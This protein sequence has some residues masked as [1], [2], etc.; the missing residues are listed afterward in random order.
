MQA[1]VLAVV[2]V[3]AL[4][5][6]GGIPTSSDVQAG[7]IVTET[8]PSAITLPAAPRVGASQQEILTGFM[9][10][11]TSPEKGYE[12]ARMFLTTAASE[13]WSPN[14]SVQVTEG[15][16]VI[17]P[18]GATSAEYSFSTRASVDAVG[19]YR[20][21]ARQG[22]Q[23]RPFSFE[24]VD[25]EWRISELQDGIVLSRYSFFANH[26]P[27]DIYFFDPRFE[28]LVPDLRY[29]PSRANV[30]QRIAAALLEGPSSW[31][32]GAT[33][34]AFPQGTSVS[35]VD[36]ADGVATVDFN[37]EVATASATDRARMLD[38]LSNSFSDIISSVLSVRMTAA[39]A[40][41]Q[42]MNPGEGDAI[43]SPAVDPAALVRQGNAFGFAS[44]SEI[45]P[46]PLSGKVLQL[47]PT[48][49]AL[50]RNKASAAVLASDGDVYL[51]REDRDNPILVDSRAGIIAPS[52]DNQ[53]YVWTVP[54]GN[55]AGLRATASNGES[56]AISS[57][58]PA[59]GTVHTLE[60]S[61]D[62]A[63]VFI[64]LST[65]DGPRLYVAGIQRSD[66]V[67]P[68]ALGELLELPV[69]EDEAI[70]ASWVDG[71]TVATLGRTDGDVVVAEYLVGG[72]RE[73]LEA[74]EGGVQVVGGNGPDQLRVLTEDGLI[75]Q[76]RGGGWQ[77]AGISA[78]FI[79]TQ[80]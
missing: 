10:A 22:T 80:Q 75:L 3:V 70:D 1:A 7:G 32:Q 15:N 55:P 59:G 16:P 51:V 4:A 61:R 26:S 6:C 18:K 47:D 57:A 48:A 42:V 35:H 23:S 36:I 14:K 67:V 9:Q 13:E 41:L 24:Q 53:H 76:Q 19:V 73:E 69:T 39:G 29:F 21:Q 31:L 43:S 65:D 68:A 44:Q 52:I 62:G 54:A 37:A 71:S 33:V 25:G 5:G 72:P 12:I 66:G 49:V 50:S 40:P 30:G 77:S 34:S 2:A 11:A 63:R 45:S 8:R 74:P 58:L 17:I 78:D 28:Y 46:F 79:A 38:Q 20:E 56:I 27:H 60:V 64:Y